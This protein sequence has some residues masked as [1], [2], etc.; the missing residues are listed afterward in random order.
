V[1]SSDRESAAGIGH[2]RRTYGAIELLEQRRYA[3]S[4]LDQVHRIRGSR[5]TRSENEY[6]KIT[7]QRTELQGAPHSATVEAPSNS[8]PN[9]LSQL[10]AATGQ[11]G[12]ATGR[13]TVQKHNIWS[14]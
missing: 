8:V 10:L 9:L 1:N 7:I 14:N 4:R 2:Q 13:S 12:K 3:R 11:L 6:P 5:S